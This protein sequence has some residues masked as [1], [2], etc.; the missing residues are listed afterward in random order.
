MDD[1]LQ[2]LKA[3]QLSMEKSA[4]PGFDDKDIEQLEILIRV[5]MQF[6]EYLEAKNSL[7]PSLDKPMQDMLYMI[8]SI[9][10]NIDSFRIV[11]H[12][13]GILVGATKSDIDWNSVAIPFIKDEFLRVYDKFVAETNFEA[14]CRLLLDLY[15]LQIVFAGVFYDCQ[16]L[17]A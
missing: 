16:F 2:Q 11:L 3:M 9:L 6:H 17:E 4:R 12:S 5:T 1:K 7:P 14:K 8:D 15:K 13:Y 10:I